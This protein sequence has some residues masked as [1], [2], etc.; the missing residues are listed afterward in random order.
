MI[1]IG[2]IVI[3]LELS[4]KISIYKIH[5]LSG[6]KEAVG[7]YY[8]DIHKVI[9]FVVMEHGCFGGKNLQVDSYRR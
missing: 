7:G 9:S 6:G 3:V 4:H 2:V 8:S 1:G 5:D